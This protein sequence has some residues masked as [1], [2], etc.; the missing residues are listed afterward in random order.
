MCGIAGVFEFAGKPIVPEA[1]GAMAD[2]QRHRGPD[3]EGAALFRIGTGQAEWWERGAGARAMPGADAGIVHRRLSIIDLSERGR[4]PMHDGSRRLWISYNGEIYNYVE[5]M[6]ELQTLGY[7][8]HSRSDTEV[9]LHA[10]RAWGAACVERFNGMFAFALWDCDRRR[11]FCARDRLGIKPFYYHHSGN[12]LS[13]ASEI[14]ALLAY[15]SAR[16][17]ANLPAISD[18]LCYSFV[19][20]DDTLFRGIR[21]LPPGHRMFASADGMVIEPYWSVRFEAQPGEEDE[22]LVERLRELLDDA[23]RIQL[24]SDVPVGAH[25]SGGIDSSAVCCLAARRVGQLST[26]TARFAEAGAFDESPH[27]RLVA[28]SIGSD[29]HEV[30]PSAGDVRDLLP[31]IVYH[32]DEPVEGPAVF[33]KFHVAQI[34]GSHVKVVLGG[35]GGDELFGGYDWYV[36]ALLTAF[37]FG[38]R[39]ALGNRPWL[40]FILAC[41]RSA[42]RRRFVR[43]LWNNLGCADI[44]QVFRRNWSRLAPGGERTL[45]RRELLNG[46]PT[47][48]DRFAAAFAALPEHHL[49]DRMFHFDVTYYLQA[50]LQSEDRL[51]MAFSVESRVPLLD[52]RIAE[53]AARAGFTRKTMPER[54]KDLLRRAV[55]G[56]V[57]APILERRDKLGFPTPIAGWLRDRRLDLIEHF[58]LGGS[59]FG[60]E[61]FQLGNVRALARQPF[62]LGSSWSE[63]LWRIVNLSVWGDRFGVTI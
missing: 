49:A 40:P 30:V 22:E 1:L 6:N 23:V 56:I 34:V 27:A 5:L 19:P 17:V 36:K 25:L 31:R 4:Q 2:I 10:Y 62:S 54:S 55:T 61:L 63:T 60:A 32:L 39:D 53:L 51:S 44:A 58:V 46:A 59:R 3:G 35:Q 21:K 8:F 29:H 11:L 15:G 57:P 12:C 41:L 48:D 7:Q 37:C 45:L 24:R 50:L 47:S 38:S 14:K 42:E 33:G 20:S 26:F 52:H 28:A 16:P 13:F 18:Y 43:S 9:I